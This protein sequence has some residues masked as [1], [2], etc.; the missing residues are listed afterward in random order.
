MINLENDT[1]KSVS[2]L[3]YTVGIEIEFK[4]T[5]R[6]E[7]NRFTHSLPPDLGNFKVRH[8][9]DFDLG[10][11]NYLK[12]RGGVLIPMSQS[13]ALWLDFKLK[14]N[15]NSRN[16]DHTCPVALKVATGKI[17]AVSGNTWKQGLSSKP[18]NYLVIPDQ[19]WLDGFNDKLGSVRQFVAAPLGSGLTV[20]GQL[21]GKE[22][23]GGIQIEAYPLK[24]KYYKQ[25]ITERT[26]EI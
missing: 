19:P 11:K 3:H 15:H 6:V 2:H 24:E 17:C 4:R 22:E 23:V 20:E 14:Y 16:I 12:K 8:I 21:T 25:I 5:L 10:E 9:E 7:E 26:K 18:Q 13:D 1:L